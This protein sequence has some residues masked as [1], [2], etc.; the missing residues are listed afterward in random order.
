MKTKIVVIGSSNTDMVMRVDEFPR[1]GET[2]MGHD[3]MQNLG[4]KGANQA[5]ACSRLGGDTAFIGKLGKDALGD[6]T[7]KQLARERMNLSHLTQTEETSSGTAFITVNSHGENSIIVDSG[8]NW[9]L[10]P[11]DIDRADALLQEAA[12]VLMQLETPI[13]TLIYA[14]QK[15]HS[16]GARVVLNPAPAPQEPLPAELL[17][18]VDLLIPN[19]TE[20][21]RISGMK[22]SEENLKQCFNKIQELGVKQVVITLGSKG[23]AM[24]VDGE[25]KLVPSHKVEVVDTTAAGDTFCGGLCVALCQ[26]KDITDAIQFACAASAITVT[27]M[28]AQQSIPYID[29]ITQHK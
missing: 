28:G 11:S 13:P 15:A 24:L 21:E 19:E 17:K 27:R 1:P 4:G 26:G 2:I 20:A 23:A 10:S 12:L 29:E 14:A 16:Y 7:L 22:A 8:A 9:K 18:N 3:F 6:N 5:V 25:V